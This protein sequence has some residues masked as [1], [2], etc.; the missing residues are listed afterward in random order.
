[1]EISDAGLKFPFMKNGNLRAFLRSDVLK[2]PNARLKWVKTA[3]VAFDYIHSQDVIQG[4]VSTRNFLVADDL[5][6]ILSDLS[7]SRIRDEESLVRPKTR[8]EKQGEGLIKVSIATE[9]FAIG[10]PIYDIVTGK[11][12]YDEL[13]D[14]DVEGLFKQGEFP[15]TANVYLGGIIRR[16]WIGEFETARQVLDAMSVYENRG[17]IIELKDITGVAY[18]VIRKIAPIWKVWIDWWWKA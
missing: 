15:P 12:S 6:I 11:P 7:G 13:E 14:D 1:L 10:S 18:G 17:H 16:C 8:Y 9:I 3:L 5:S 4:D 2:L